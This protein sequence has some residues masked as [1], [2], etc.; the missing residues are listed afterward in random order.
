MAMQEDNTRVYSSV[1]QDALAFKSST[2]N[3][4][5]QD[6]EAATPSTK[7]VPAQTHDHQTGIPYTRLWFVCFFTSFILHAIV[8]YVLVNQLS[9]VELETTC[10]DGPTNWVLPLK[11]TI[12]GQLGLFSL[13]ALVPL[14]QKI[15]IWW[16]NKPI[17]GTLFAGSIAYAILSVTAKAFLGVS[18]IFFVSMFPFETR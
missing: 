9:N 13:F 15:R 17:E 16:F 18:Y 4:E 8:W 10:Y 14:F 7:A 6:Q 5:S 1:P 11:I 2:D 12:Y 3:A